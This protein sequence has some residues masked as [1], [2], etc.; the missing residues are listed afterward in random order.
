M[1]QL[2][3]LINIAK[4]QSIVAFVTGGRGKKGT[5][6]RTRLMSCL[7]TYRTSTIQ[8]HINDKSSD[9]FIT[10]CL[11]KETRDLNETKLAREQKVG[12]SK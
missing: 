4:Q 2:R 8:S 9:Y 3:L 5:W 6:E 11:P 7:P 12:T 10:V 1:L